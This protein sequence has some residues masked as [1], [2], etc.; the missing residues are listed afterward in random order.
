MKLR[1]ALFTFAFAT[2]STSIFGKP[3]PDN[4][5]NGLDKIVTN[6]LIQQGKITAVPA[7]QT[8]VTSAPTSRPPP[9]RPRRRR[10]MPTKR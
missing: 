1:I 6:N 10:S 7:T 5:G 3:V 9:A 2:I 4:L 8:T